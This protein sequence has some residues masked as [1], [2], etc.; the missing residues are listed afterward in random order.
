MSED[1]TDNKAEDSGQ[2]EDF[3]LLNPNSAIINITAQM[4]TAYL[5]EDYT[6]GWLPAGVEDRSFS[7]TLKSQNKESAFQE[8]QEKIQQNIDSWDVIKTLERE[9]VIEQPQIEAYAPVEIPPSTA[10][11]HEKTLHIQDKECKKK[12]KE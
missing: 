9:Q 4:A 5:K 11:S 6:L 10:I 3:T 8:L 7:V 1:K 2:E 12:E